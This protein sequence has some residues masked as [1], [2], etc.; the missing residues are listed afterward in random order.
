VT[1]PAQIELRSDELE[2]VLLP[3]LGA[4]LHRLRA[5][6]KDL[7]RTPDE[8]AVHRD[9]PFFWGAYVMAPWCNRIRPG[10]VEVA[11]RT[12]DVAPNFKDGSAIHGQVSAV[13]WAVDTDGTLRATGGGDGWPWPYEVTCHATVDGPTLTLAYRLTNH[14]D[15]AMPAGL[16]LH[17]WFRRPVEVQVPA[18]LVYPTNAESQPSPQPVGDA[19][20]LRARRPLAT[21][22]DASWA[23]LSEPRIELAWPEHGLSARIE[24][25]A[26][27]LLV[28]GASPVDVGAVA[29]EP[30]THGPDGIRR[31]LAGEPDAPTM[32]APA[33]SLSLTLRLTAG[34]ARVLR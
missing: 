28:A 9:D 2:V 7:L 33:A 27:R 8:P 13:A 10:P 34:L 11:G 32:L 1:A 4:R 14:A 17:P 21:D 24:V 5:F 22:L 3:G 19:F 18:S 26:D 30:Q 15:E 16:G 25:D 29:I 12:V 31:L 23:G 6:G 20:D